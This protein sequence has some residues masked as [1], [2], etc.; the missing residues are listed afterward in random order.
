MWQGISH[1]GV[2]PIHFAQRLRQDFDADSAFEGVFL[3][4]SAET[5]LLNDLHE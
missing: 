4:W 1:Q 5:H 3:H 2:L